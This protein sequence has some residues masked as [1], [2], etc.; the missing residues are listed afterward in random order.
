MGLSAMQNMEY[1]LIGDVIP[2][3]RKFTVLLGIPGFKYIKIT[4][5]TEHSSVKWVVL[6]DNYFRNP[7]E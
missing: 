5:N 3:L 2:A 1:G 6:N 7:E 4:N